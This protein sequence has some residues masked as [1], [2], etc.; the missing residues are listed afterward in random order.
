MI[1]FFLYPSVTFSRFAIRALTASGSLRLV[2]LLSRVSDFRVNF[3]VDLLLL[4]FL[5]CVRS[6]CIRSSVACVG[7]ERGG[8]RSR[9]VGVLVI[10]RLLFA[11]AFS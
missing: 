1:R 5:S 6:L 11:T 3:I 10:T 9:W 2:C 4:S 7:S 8:I